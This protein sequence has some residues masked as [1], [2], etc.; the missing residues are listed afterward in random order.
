MTK[1]SDDTIEID[2]SF[3]P[4]QPP[5]V[6]P[7]VLRRAMK[8]GQK[9]RLVF[10]ARLFWDV[11]A[12]LRRGWIKKGETTEWDWVRAAVLAGFDLDSINDD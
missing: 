11:E 4:T 10:P 12:E 3:P 9:A 2:L 7:A 6:D 8:Y 1:S 5:S